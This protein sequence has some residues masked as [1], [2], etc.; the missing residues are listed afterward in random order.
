MARADK[1]LSLLVPGHQT[2][3]ICATARESD[4]TFIGSQH[5]NLVTAEIHRHSLSD[6]NLRFGADQHRLRLPLLASR[7]EK[8]EKA[9]AE[10]PDSEQQAES[11]DGL[12][13][14]ASPTGV[15]VHNRHA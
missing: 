7:N 9:N 1:L 2:A 11:H 5:K 12:T 14:K 15:I 3:Q 4:D 8:L 10:R 13:Q 6:R